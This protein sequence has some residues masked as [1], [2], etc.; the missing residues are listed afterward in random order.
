M[1][2]TREDRRLA[3]SIYHV[4]CDD[5]ETFD[6]D[7]EPNLLLKLYMREW[8][9]SGTLPS[10]SCYYLQQAAPTADRIAA[11][12]EAAEARGREGERTAI[13]AWLRAGLVSGPAETVYADAIERGE[14]R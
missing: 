12:R 5:G 9:R 6:A 14:H 10:F 1:T 7:G 2:T 4:V 8:I 11:H 3:L 13:V